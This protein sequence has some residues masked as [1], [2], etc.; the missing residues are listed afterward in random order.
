MIVVVVIMKDEIICYFGFK[1]T[2]G[3]LCH[4]FLQ[5][6]LGSVYWEDASVSSCGVLSNS[7]KCFCSCLHRISSI[8]R[9][10]ILVF[11]ASC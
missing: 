2:F 6:N 5:F 11:L 10:C 8:I 9:C 7:E 4:V 1:N 3:V